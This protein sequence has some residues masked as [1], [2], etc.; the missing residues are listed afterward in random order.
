VDVNPFRRI[1]DYP[2][3]ERKLDALQRSI[4][5]VGLWEGVI[6]RKKGNRVEIAFGHHRIE[7]ARRLK[8]KSV[9][10]IIRT[11]SEEQMLK[12]MGRENLEDY[13]ADF[14]TMLETWEAAVTFGPALGK[15]SQQ[16]DIA[17]LLG[18]LRSD[19]KANATARACDAASKLITGGYLSRED[20]IDISVQTALDICSSVQS[21]HEQMEKMA[22]KSPTP[23]IRQMTDRGKRQYAKAGKKTA[24]KAR[25]GVIAKK[26][27]R[28]EVHRQAV[29]EA[30]KTKKESPVFSLA[31]KALCDQMDKMLVA[32]SVGL[33]LKDIE[34]ALGLIYEDPEGDDAMKRVDFELKR[35]GQRSDTWRERLERSNASKSTV[36]RLKQIEGGA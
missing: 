24:E 8:L 9:P 7:A 30:A 3:V 23:K 13:N 11:L 16:I 20:L 34:K 21:K 18:W 33:K 31:I 2:F 28:G 35:I 1:G 27:V 15:K 19:G 25:R 10:I 14:L 26:E 4:E 29:G 36:V 5:D 22:R 32:D 17:S 12:F 6:G